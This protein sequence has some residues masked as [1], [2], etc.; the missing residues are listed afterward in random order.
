MMPQPILLSKH[1]GCAERGLRVLR[2]LRVCSISRLP[3]DGGVCPDKEPSRGSKS[4]RSHLQLIPVVDGHLGG[5]W[6]LKVIQQVCALS[7]GIGH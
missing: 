1:L 4:N 3:P 7:P 6:S 2:G 5:D